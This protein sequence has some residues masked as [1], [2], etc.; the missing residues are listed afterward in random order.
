[1]RTQI[2]R[3]S[4]AFAND[5]NIRSLSRRRVDYVKCFTFVVD[6]P[7]DRFSSQTP[8]ICAV[9]NVRDVFVGAKPVW[10][11]YACHLKFLHNRVSIIRLRVS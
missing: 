9:S 8:P 4:A 7:D 6:A 2:G 10:L 11:I 5:R 1:V 3:F